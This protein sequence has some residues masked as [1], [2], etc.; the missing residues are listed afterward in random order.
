MQCKKKKR[1]KMI[2]YENLKKKNNINWILYCGRTTIFRPI[3]IKVARLLIISAL[4]MFGS[5]FVSIFDSSQIFQPRGK[6][7][8]HS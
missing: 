1:L 3:I 4:P 8:H 5:M 2:R 6:N 7:F